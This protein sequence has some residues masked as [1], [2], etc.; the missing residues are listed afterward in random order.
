MSTS[1]AQPRSAGALSPAA[2]GCSPHL[3]GG[4][5]SLVQAASTHRGGNPR[6]GFPARSWVQDEQPR[7]LQP[8]PRPRHRF[9]PH[10]LLGRARVSA[11]LGRVCPSSITR[12]PPGLDRP[13]AA[14]T[15][16][17]N[18]IYIKNHLVGKA[19]QE[20]AQGGGA[21]PPPPALGELL[22][23]SFG[24][25]HLKKELVF[26]IVKG[27]VKPQNKP[28]ELREGWS[29]AGR[30]RVGAGGEAQAGAG[31]QRLLRG[32]LLQS[33]P[34]AAASSCAGSPRA[35]RGSQH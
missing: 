26:Y 22:F 32:L 24:I 18:F 21:A 11:V 7:P 16:F 17:K 30:T 29:R 14:P 33:Q 35:P 15:H 6:K 19:L 2:G 23:G 5:S 20:C 3:R 13:R 12:S 1:T 34:P 9:N 27:R 25:K 4:I 8:P 28:D 31:P 10:L